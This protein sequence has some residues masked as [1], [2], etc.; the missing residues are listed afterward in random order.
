L[1]AK[2]HH[3]VPEAYLN[4]FR[5]EDGMLTA[6]RKEKGAKPFRVTPSNVALERYYYANTGEDGARDTDTFEQIFSQVES[7]WPSILVALSEGARSAQLTH[8]LLEFACL[9]RAR[10]PAA[11]DAYELM[12]ADSV[13]HLARLLQRLGKLPEMPPGS[14]DILERFEVS[15]DPESSLRAIAMVLEGMMNR[16]LP[17]LGFMVIH[18][19]TQIEFI[20]SDNPVM[21]FVPH[22][23]QELIKPYE[24]RPNAP[25]EFLFPLTPR[26]LLLGRSNDLERYNLY[27]L[28]HG[29]ISDPKTVKR[30]NRLVAKF[31][32]G[33]LLARDESPASLAAKY[34]EVSPVM[35]T[36]AFPRPDGQTVMVHMEFSKRRKKARW[37]SAQTS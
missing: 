20:T 6:F 8:N 30:A 13:A 25:L 28:G 29:D 27:G 33:L 9:Q 4:A 12:R 14:E 35:H 15:V 17:S 23:D 5:S 32:Y 16:V 37:S 18:N 34:A 2:R 1:S 19:M 26:M 36:T 31:G 24:M 21:W 11:R 7:G 22:R 3:Y 10:V